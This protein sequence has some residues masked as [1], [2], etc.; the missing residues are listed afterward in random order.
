MGC[1]LQWKPCL[2]FQPEGPPSL[3]HRCKRRRSNSLSWGASRECFVVARTVGAK[4]WNLL[5]HAQP[6]SNDGRMENSLMPVNTIYKGNNVCLRPPQRHS[7]GVFIGNRGSALPRQRQLHPQLHTLSPKHSPLGVMAGH[8]SI[9]NYKHGLTHYQPCLRGDL[10]SG[11][12][13]M[14]RLY[15]GPLLQCGR[16]QCEVFTVL[17]G[18]RPDL[19]GRR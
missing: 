10:R 15:T 5:T 6:S 14:G 7:T 8:Y 18:L 19:S 2:S 12:Y 13:N 3:H 4:C 17:D 11:S 16:L 1:H 9:I